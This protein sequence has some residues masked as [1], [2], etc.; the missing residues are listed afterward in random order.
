MRVENAHT[1]LKYEQNNQYVQQ[2]LKIGTPNCAL[3]MTSSTHLDKQ[4]IANITIEMG[5]NTSN[6]LYPLPNMGTSSI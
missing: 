3:W 1:V 2:K 6:L 5:A 4:L